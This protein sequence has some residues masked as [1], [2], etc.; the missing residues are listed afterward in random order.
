MAKEYK[1][2]IVATRS[3]RGSMEGMVISSPFDVICSEYFDG[4][5]EAVSARVRALT[6]ELKQS[7]YDQGK[8]FTIDAFLVKGQRK[9]AGYDKRRRERCANFIAA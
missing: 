9:P 2:R 6:D 3:E 8:G 7:A 1:F 4:S 5:L